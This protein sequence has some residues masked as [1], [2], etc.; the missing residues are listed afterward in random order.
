MIVLFSKTN[1]LCSRRGDEAGADHPLRNCASSPRRPQLLTFSCLFLLSLAVTLRAQETP[2]S[3]AFKSAARWFQT[4]VYDTAE[5]EFQKFAA[6]FP[7]SPMLAEAVLFQARA[8]LE[9]TNLPAA[10]SILNANLPRAGLL[11]DQ[12]R[13]RLGTA[14]LQSGD[15]AA[16]VDSFALIG[17]QFTNSALLLE[18]GYGEAIARFKMREFDRVAA[19]LQDPNG[20]FQ[21][22]V[23]ARPSD[24]FNVRGRGHLLLAESLFELKLYRAAEEAAGGLSENSLTAEAEWDRRHLLCRIQVAKRQFDAALIQT[25]NLLRQAGVAGSQNLVADSVAMQGG[26]LQQMNRLDEAIQ[27]YTNN[28]AASV[29]VEHRRAAL[30]NIIE[31][32]LAQ[33]KTAEAEQMLGAFLEANP[34]DATSD[35]AMLTSGELHLRMH[36]EEAAATNAVSIPPA[37]TNH[38]QLALAQFEKL[39]ETRTN[40]PLRGKAWLNKGWCHWLE[41][42]VPESARAFRAATEWLPFSEDLAVAR[43]KLA[44]ALFRQGELTNA[45]QYYR[46]VTNDFAQVARVRESLFDQALFQIVRANITL[47]DA[48][49]ATD[50]MKYLLEWFPDSTS[51]ERSLWLVGQ[52]LIRARQQEQARQVFTNFIHRFPDRPLLPN[53]ELAVARTYFHENDWPA[54]IREYEGWLE[55][56]PTN[57]LRPRAEFNRAWAGY[58]AGLSNIALGL[59]TNFVAQF[60]ANE[61]APRAQFW[62]ADEFYRRGDFPN[63][64]RNYQIILENTNWPRTRLTYEARMRA[65]QSA[66]AAELWKNAVEHF[67]ALINDPDCPVEQAAEA[68]IAL[69]DTYLKEG[70]TTAGPLDKFKEAR[71]AFE[72]IIQLPLFATNL[73][74]RRLVP[75]AWGRVADCY[76]QLASQDPEQYKNATNA[77]W[78]VMRPESP[79]DISVRSLAAFGL[80]RTLESEAGDN[81]TPSERAALLK[82]A[83]EHYF[84]IV[85]G[86]NLRDDEKSDPVWVEKAGFAAARIKESQGEWRIALNVYQRLLEIP[87]L[88]PL[89]PRLQERME[90][91]GKQS[92]GAGN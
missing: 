30:L 50:A 41:D 63:A 90:R 48:P 77:Y 37:P 24:A 14:Y 55:R 45:L 84:T 73:L 59:F 75:L 1:L 61:L 13:Y 66:F 62:V 11:A 81:K 5:R 38:L 43:F 29:P 32:K 47:G 88:A 52:E 12:Y 57:A 56:Y 86:Q 35:V 23:K 33:D 89:R 7:Q 22:G 76:L 18:A 16:A 71:N 28:L 8:A 25:T 2:E 83:F 54:A 91:V 58:R 3:R 53:V 51:S 85:I 65:G 27:T 21:R 42:R 31:L 10:I 49:S 68:F 6:Q 20:A 78:Q 70:L 64:L 92:R 80:A 17:R 72:K 36:F 60:P 4:G 40:S 79:A 69:G 19:L 39:I 9:Q 74:T 67:S 46:S 87:E 82:A 44:D 34:G 26:I 15:H